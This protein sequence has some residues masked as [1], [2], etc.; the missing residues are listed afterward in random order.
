MER[1]TATRREFVRNAGVSVPLWNLSNPVRS[2]APTAK[3]VW[4]VGFGDQYVRLT[5]TVGWAFYA[6][7]KNVVHAVDIYGNERWRYETKENFP[8]LFPTADVV[9]LGDEGNVS[10]LS[11]TDGSERW[12]RNGG[13]PT[14]PLLSTS[15]ITRGET[16]VALSRE[17]GEKRWSVTP[18]NGEWVSLSD[19]S[20]GH[21]YAGTDEGSLVAISTRNGIVDWNATISEGRRILARS[22]AG[23]VVFATDYETGLLHAVDADTGNKQWSVRSKSQTY[24]F[25]GVIGGNTV[26]LTDGGTLRAL[27]AASGTVLWHADIGTNTDRQL[28]LVG[29]TLYVGTH[30]RLFA[31][32]TED[33]SHR[34]QFSTD[35][36][37]YHFPIGTTRDSLIVFS[38]KG[39]EEGR[40]TTY[41]LSLRDGH[42]RWQ[43][44]HSTRTTGDHHIS[45]KTVYFSTVSGEIRAITDPGRSQLYDTLRTVVSPLG[46]TSGGLLGAALLGGGYHLYRNH[47]NE[48]ESATEPPVPTWNGYELH[49]KLDD[50]THLARTP[51]GE[52]VHLRRFH[53]APE[54][55]ERAAEE[56]AKI[57]F[58]GVQSVHDW[59]IDPEPWIAVE[60]VEGRTLAEVGDSF[61]QRDIVSTVA[62]T[63]EIVHRAS[64]E[65]VGHEDLT[66]GNIVVGS[67]V[68]VT[69]WRF[70]GTDGPEKVSDEEIVSRL[71]NIAELLLTRNDSEISE[72][73]ADVLE[74]ATA[75][76]PDERYE[77]AL[78]F[79]DML[80]WTMRSN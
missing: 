44:D 77:S 72:P 47:D 7:T 53:D 61:D 59:G 70:T 65:G 13:K 25:P 8:T 20:D 28:R 23:G 62:R 37:H 57:E 75:S 48:G 43:Y 68:T 69:N 46:L 32:S 66:A 35:D 50:E 2:Y 12:R 67:D 74:T 30:E 60:R 1:R 38:R 24:D 22:S 80:R 16:I 36:D 55:F 78:E 29:N 40:E 33:G 15:I 3:T 76:N 19:A 39:K 73:L 9:Y 5:R 45:D 14:G 34:W 6:Q 26:Y 54:D 51:K 18:S 58:D 56:W 10:A 64:K 52:S 4:S 27:F 31:F 41:A 11:A 21:I 17:T 71:G 63:A 79:A 49:E 42:V